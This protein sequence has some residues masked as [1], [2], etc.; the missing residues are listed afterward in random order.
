[1]ASR[2]YGVHRS[3]V[4]EIRTRSYQM[5]RAAAPPNA[6][7]VRSRLPVIS[8]LA[9]ARFQG[10][11]FGKRYSRRCADFGGYMGV[12][13]A[14]FRTAGPRPRLT[15]S[16]APCRDMDVTAIARMAPSVNSRQND[17]ILPHM[18]GSRRDLCADSVN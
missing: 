6:H 4:G 14:E 16:G 18:R 12:A 1:M 15:G 8:P 7:S 17:G 13:Y 9:I 11:G 10:V 3:T 5:D 2:R